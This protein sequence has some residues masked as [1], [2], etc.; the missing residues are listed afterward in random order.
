VLKAL[1][2]H[3]HRE[4]L[5]GPTDKILAAVSGGLDS[6]VMLH[7]LHAAGYQLAV[8]HVNFQLR[9]ADSDQDEAFVQAQC[10][11]LALPCFTTRVDTEEFVKKHKV[12]I[13][14]AARTLRYQWFAEVAAANGFT[15]IATAHHADDQVE[16]ILMNL[17]HGQS[18][19]GLTGIPVRNGDVIRPL[20]F[21]TRTEIEQYAATHQIAW[22]EDAS[23]QT[24]HYLRNQLRL[25]VVPLL[26]KINPNLTATM[27]R[28]QGLAQAEWRFLN[29]AL[30]RWKATHVQEQG[31][32]WKLLKADLNGPDAVAILFHLLRPRGFNLAQC[33]DLVQALEGQPGKRFLSENFQAVIDRDGVWVGPLPAANGAVEIARG[34]TEVTLGTRHL[35]FDWQPSAEIPVDVNRACLDLDQLAFPLVWRKWQPGDRF[36]PLGM[37]GEKKVSDYLVDAKVPALEK[38]RVTVLVSGNRVVWLVGHRI[39]HP[40]R[41]TPTTQ[42][43]VLI[44]FQQAAVK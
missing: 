15:R 40:A 36:V 16:T 34:T 9:G 20:L 41:I 3:I 19:E 17:V 38:D 21:A 10:H 43:R 28:A 12:S 4:G 37:L 13:Q 42:K 1:Q 27:Q 22:R 25:D 11:R 14:M 35:A 33:E 2:Q 31:E 32:E 18:L 44:H 24:G 5:C 7:L 26:Q 6:M 8:A 23:N 30:E 29:E 39:A